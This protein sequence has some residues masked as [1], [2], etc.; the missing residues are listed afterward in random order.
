[1]KVGI[2]DVGSNTVRL[3]V[4]RQ[5]DDGELE[6]VLAERAQ[7]GLGAQIERSGIVSRS[8]RLAAARRVARYAAAARGEGCE[9]IDLVI[10]APGRQ[11]EN[12]DQLVAELEYAAGLSARVLSVEQE[13]M[14]AYA[15][16]IRGVI[17]PQNGAV[18]VC[19]V[20]GGSTEIA[21]GR[22][23]DQP[24]WLRSFD[25]GSLRLTC[26]HLDG[27]PPSRRDVRRARERVRKVLADADPPDL[28]L[29]LAT[30]GAARALRRLVGRSLGPDELAE[31]LDLATRMS[32]AKLAKRGGIDPDRA[33]TLA[34]GAVILAEVQELL[35]VP[36]E[37]ARGGL[38][39]G[40]A[41]ELFSRMLSRAA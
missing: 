26:R 12:A 3:L 7:L 14:L 27:D 1:M 41:D 5:G 6:T 38:R 34:A 21:V 8:K 11:S 24:E 15:G 2:I 13:G 35:G 19:D 20:G 32:S 9:L 22:G 30:G 33:R 4:A 40:L 37:V 25:V 17:A 18:A 23:G 10:T 39:E 31:A 36:M 16:A 29:G 28:A